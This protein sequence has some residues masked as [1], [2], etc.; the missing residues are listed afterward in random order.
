[1]SSKKKAV[2]V[3]IRQAIAN[4]SD[5]SDTLMLNVEALKKVAKIFG[6]VA[7]VYIDNRREKEWLSWDNLMK[8]CRT[9]KIDMIVMRSLSNLGRN[10]ADMLK[11]VKELSTLGIQAYFLTEQFYSDSEY[12]EK[13]VSFYCSMI[14]EEYT[15]KKERLT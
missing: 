13:I 4:Q 9:E 8:D 15:N 7:G 1:M 3:Y 2:A 12:F 5:F 11:K 10:T 14:E 6:N